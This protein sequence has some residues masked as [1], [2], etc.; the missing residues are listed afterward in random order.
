[1]FDTGEMHSES[2]KHKNKSN[3]GAEGSTDRDLQSSKAEVSSQRIDGLG[4][5]IELESLNHSSPSPIEGRPGSHH[6][7][8]VA[9]SCS[10]LSSSVTNQ[11]RPNTGDVI[12]VHFY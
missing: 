4:E 9:F 1:M 10:L 8:Q 3:G 11:A 7:E 6:L 2:A 12:Q 5:A